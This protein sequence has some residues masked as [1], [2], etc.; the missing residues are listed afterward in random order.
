MELAMSEA[1]KTTLR[2]LKKL[3]LETLAL[4]LA[5]CAVSVASLGAQSA[6]I[7]RRPVRHMVTPAYPEL[8]KKLN[9]TGTARIEVTIGSDGVVKHTRV[10][11]GHPVLAAEAERAAEKSTFEPGP[12]ESVEVIEFKF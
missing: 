4:A 1:L 3:P 6:P 10:I 11:G 8:A 2:K 7:T 9:L 5:L 12:A